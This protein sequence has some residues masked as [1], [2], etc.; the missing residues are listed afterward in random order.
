MGAANKW[1]TYLQGW[2]GV[3]EDNSRTI[4]GGFGLLPSWHWP[5]R[6]NDLLVSILWKLL[7]ILA[8]PYILKW[9][10]QKIF[11]REKIWW[12]SSPLL[13]FYWW[14]Q[15]YYLSSNC[16]IYKIMS[17]SAS[18]SNSCRCTFHFFK[19]GDISLHLVWWRKLQRSLMSR[20]MTYM[21]IG[22]QATISQQ[23]M[24]CIAHMFTLTNLCN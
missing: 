11:A 8:K 14:V 6:R 1:T 7:A 21:S 18:L 23:L 4:L 13:P 16:S 9:K 22:H 5:W 15:N 20:K 3:L 10:V 24:S 19:S 12:F 2:D 17:V